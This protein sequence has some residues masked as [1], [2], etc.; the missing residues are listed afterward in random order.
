MKILLTN[1]DGLH[2]PG[3]SALAEAVSDIGDLWIVAPHEE[4]SGASH[5]LTM[6]SPLRVVEHGPRRFASTGTPVDCVY[7]GIHSLLGGM[8]DLVLSGVNKG[9]NLGDDV[10]YSGTVGAAR[11]AAL[12]DLPALAVSLAVEGGGDELHFQTAA[13]AAGLVIKQL[14]ENPLPKGVF[15]N[16]NVPNVPWDALEGIQVCSLGRRHYEPW[17]ERREDPRGKNYFWIGGAPLG[18]GMHEGS[19]GWWIRRGHAA[20]T[21]LGLDATMAD[22]IPKI[23]HWPLWNREQI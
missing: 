7:L 16:L 6:N 3:I 11:E 10:L 14:T 21:P 9:A 4:R 5:A 18:S 22:W 1:D 23:E 12:N 13:R 17:V 2:A 15:L 8:P 20:L 19:D